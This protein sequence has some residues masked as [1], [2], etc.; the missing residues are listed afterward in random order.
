V[1]FIRGDSL[2]E[3]IDH[4]HRDDALKNDPGRRALELRK[5][6]RRFLDV[7]NAIDYAHSRGAIHRDIKPANISSSRNGPGRRWESP[8]RWPGRGIPIRYSMVGVISSARSAE[9]SSGK[10]LR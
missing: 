3:A 1:R 7:C 4:F 10:L 2:K 9:P 8:R 6:L 5:L